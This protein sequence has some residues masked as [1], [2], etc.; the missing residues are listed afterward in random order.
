MG[1]AAMTTTPVA[2]SFPDEATYT[3]GPVVRASENPHQLTPAF[4]PTGPDELKIDLTAIFRNNGDFPAPV[5]DPQFILKNIS[6]EQRQALEAGGNFLVIV[7]FNGGHQYFARVPEAAREYKDRLEKMLPGATTQVV[8]AVPEKDLGNNDKYGP[9]YI[10]IAEIN[11]DKFRDVLTRLA[12]LSWNDP[13]TAHFIRFDVNTRVWVAGIFRTTI[14]GDVATVTKRIRWIIR[15]TLYR[16]SQFRQLIMAA[17]ATS[18]DSLDKRVHD[19]T[20]TIEVRELSHDRDREWVIMVAPCT[21]KYDVFEKIKRR[22]CS[23]VYHDGMYLITPFPEPD[24]SGRKDNR[25]RC[26]VCKLERHR[27]F[28]CKYTRIPDWKG[29]SDQVTASL[30]SAARAEENNG[31]V[32]RTRDGR[33]G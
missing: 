14:P 13:F 6:A 33:R 18:D 8:K 11:D 25:P 2:W 24:K 27:A 23:I 3:G 7:P 19:V 28:D 1:D 30:D 9:P 31:I 10:L 26:M 22:I 4:Q 16:D 29:P 32:T 17:T 21:T 5:I 15:T 12:T 20:T